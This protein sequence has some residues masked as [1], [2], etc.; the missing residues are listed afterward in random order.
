MPETFIQKWKHR[1][2]NAWL[3]LI[4]RAWV[5]HG[6]PMHWELKGGFDD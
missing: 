4:G 2:R 1:F 5:G 3:V 6:N